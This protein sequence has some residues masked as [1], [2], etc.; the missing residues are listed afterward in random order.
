MRKSRIIFW[1]VCIMCAILLIKGQK[2]TDDIFK[3]KTLVKVYAPEAEDIEKALDSVLWKSG[4]WKE[5][6]IVIVQDIKYADII[7]NYAKSAD[8]TYSKFAFSPFVIAYNVNAD[9]YKELKKAKTLISSEYN[10]DS[11][12]IDF[13]KVIKEV[14]NDGEWA[15]LGIR[16][17]EKIKIFYPSKE[18]CYWNDFYDF[19]LITVNNGSY[20]KTNAEMQVAQDIIKQFEESPYTEAISDFYVKA[21]RVGGF[22]TNVFWVLPEKKVFDLTMQLN[23]TARILYPTRTIYFNYYIKTNELG[24]KV[25]E[26]AENNSFYEKLQHEFYRS[27]RKSQIPT[28]DAVYSEKDTFNI[29]DIPTN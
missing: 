8:S 13:L 6:E 18:P 25:M 11:Y 14:L 22:P 9:Y 29:V 16:N 26:N 2:F 4:L 20:P 10:K 27:E 3:E 1:I 28:R 7:V 24:R 19:M 15:N 5:Y 12:E 23:K 21:E 17:L